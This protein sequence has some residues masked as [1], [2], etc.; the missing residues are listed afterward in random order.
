MA[1][2]L[3]IGFQPKC[4]NNQKQESV[5]VRTLKARVTHIANIWVRF[6]ATSFSH[7]FYL[8]INEYAKKVGKS[9]HLG[10][11]KSL[12]NL[13][14]TFI[15][16]IRPIQKKIAIWAISCTS[17]WFYDISINQA[18]KNTLYRIQ[19]LSKSDYFWGF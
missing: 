7:S 11:N 3:I 6:C 5:H 15:L 16:E 14:S 13:C 12:H 18:T 9:C 10:V 4:I 8:V 2:F 19:K 17:T 1:I